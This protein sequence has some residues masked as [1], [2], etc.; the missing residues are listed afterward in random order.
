MNQILCP[1]D[2]SAASSFAVNY[3]AA[4]SEQLGARLVLLHAYEA[5][6]VFS[7]AP[8]TSIRD[9][10]QQLRLGAQ[11]KLDALSR[12][13]EKAHPGLKVDTKVLAGLGSERILDA[14]QDLHADLIVMGA[15][16]TS[17]LSR[18]LIGSTTAAVIRDAQCP[19]LCIPKE[20][21]FKGIRRIAFAT[22]LQEDN[23]AS[24]MTV[25]PFAKKFDAELSFVYVDDK[26]LL[27]S[28]EAIDEMTLKIRR[29]VKYPKLSGFIAKNPS[30]TKGLELFLKKQ[31]ADLL[32]MFTHPRRAGD[33][34]F[35]QSVTNL[36][37]HQARI[38][39]LAIRRTDVPVLP[40]PKK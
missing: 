14:A 35:N 12:K 33:F 9:A 28:E 3:A 4:L 31:P 37:S 2:F 26:H 17:R 11:K 21:R 18:L 32:V 1:T 20:S 8:L 19:V 22:D 6:V 30:I 16:G 13:L 15:T 5:P 36:M 34:L 38:P 40:N 10:R 27:H 29:R 39:L 23:I 24:A 7:Q 25:T